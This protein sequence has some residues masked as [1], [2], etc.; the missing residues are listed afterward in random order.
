MALFTSMDKAMQQY[1]RKKD[2]PGDHL[3]KVYLT[4]Q[5]VLEFVFN[6]LYTTLFYISGNIKATVVSEISYHNK[7]FQKLLN[8]EKVL[9]EENVGI[10]MA[11][12]KEFV[13]CIK[14]I[15]PGEI[16]FFS[17]ECAYACFDKQAV[18]LTLKKCCN[19]SQEN[20]SIFELYNRYENHRIRTDEFRSIYKFYEK[21]IE[22]G[23]VL[24]VRK[25]NISTKPQE[26]IN[27]YT[28]DIDEGELKELKF[29]PF[30]VRV[31]RSKTKKKL[32]WYD[33]CGNLISMQD[34]KIMIAW[35]NTSPIVTEITK[36][37]DS[38]NPTDTVYD[39]KVKA[40][41][42][43]LYSLKKFSEIFKLI[44]EYCKGRKKGLSVTLKT[45]NATKKGFE[46]VGIAFTC[47]DNDVKVFKVQYEGNNINNDISSITPTDEAEFAQIC[48]NKSENYIAFVK[49]KVK[50]QIKDKAQPQK[51]DLIAEIIA[52]ND[53]EARRTI[54]MLGEYKAG[55]LP[56]VSSYAHEA[57][58]IDQF[59][60]TQ[61]KEFIMLCGLPGSGKSERGYQEAKRLENSGMTEKDAAELYPIARSYKDNVN[62]K[63]INA[64]LETL[65]SP[66]E[67]DNNA[68]TRISLNGIRQELIRNNEYAT[69]EYLELISK[70]RATAAFAKGYSVIYD[71]MNIDAN[72]RKEML[73]IAKNMG[74]K[75]QKL[76]ITNITQKQ[77]ESS[78][79]GTTEIFSKEAIAS[80]LDKLSKNYPTKK[81]GWTKI[82]EYGS[83]ERN[84][85][86][87]T[88]RE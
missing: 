7:N 16:A 24:S 78:L 14:S 66:K 18:K 62:R 67:R 44:K 63:S 42:E 69:G 54:D 32:L 19:L 15:S 10:G 40:L 82:V 25:M 23:T 49:D 77:A 27:R 9:K 68:Y 17:N 46:A 65:K 88:E 86:Q 80:M 75:E 37:E 56:L 26:I 45:Y 83:R 73:G 1:F 8:L 51:L 71:A 57:D 47:I 48:T 6:E 30:K 59:I 3:Y 28:G 2:A 36:K 60:N 39:E 31:T 85:S 55:E 38:D 29:G 72:A 79:M 20:I 70:A 43:K 22:A 50:T 35:L 87:Q 52:K 58:K 74:V 33:D 41:I 76:V 64:V 34:V 84:M 21:L 13:R 53:I 5:T 61:P 12:P 81:E 4:N 11:I